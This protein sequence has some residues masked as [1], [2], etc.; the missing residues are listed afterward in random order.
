[1]VRKPLRML[2]RFT[3]EWLRNS[4]RSS[5][6]VPSFAGSGLHQ[7]SLHV[8]RRFITS[9]TSVSLMRSLLIRSLSWQALSSSDNITSLSKK[10][11]LKESLSLAAAATSC[12]VAE[13]SSS[14]DKACYSSLSVE[15]LIDSS[16]ASDRPLS[17]SKR[18]SAVRRSVFLYDNVDVSPPLL[19][20]TLLEGPTAG[21]RHHIHIES[22]Q[23]YLCIH[24]GPTF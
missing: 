21:C 18:S 3:G 19:F 23:N 5:F 13:S 14:V 17:L 22:H 6:L 20:L 4:S 2:R 9:S 16:T 1:M 10:K 15:G 8:L 24:V 12:S 11:K 7:T